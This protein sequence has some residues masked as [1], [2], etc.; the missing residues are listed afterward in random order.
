MR[1]KSS[2][3]PS[4]KN[5]NGKRARHLECML[6]HEES[7]SPF[8]AWANTPSNRHSTHSPKQK[9]LCFVISNFKKEKH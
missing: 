6:V 2:P 9:S 1:K 7:S 4:T 5:L 3:H 8:L